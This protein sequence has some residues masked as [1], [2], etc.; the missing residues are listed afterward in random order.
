M[1][2]DPLSRKLRAMKKTR[3]IP[4]DFSTILPTTDPKNWFTI[5][6]GHYGAV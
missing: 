1:F 5:D 3:C 4:A 6:Q 2:I